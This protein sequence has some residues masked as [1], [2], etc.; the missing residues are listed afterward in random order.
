MGYDV[1]IWSEIN[2]SWCIKIQNFES[3]ILILEEILRVA[4]IK[5]VKSFQVLINFL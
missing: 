5:V 4:L 2:K 1:W 3:E